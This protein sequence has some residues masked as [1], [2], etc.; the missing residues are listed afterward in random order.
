MDYLGLIAFIVGFGW[1]PIAIIIAPIIVLI[2]GS[3]KMREVRWKLTRE[4]YKKYTGENGSEL[5]SSEKVPTYIHS[6]YGYY[7]AR[8]VEE[9]DGYYAYVNI[10]SG[11]D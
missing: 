3:K 4:E 7:G 9:D 5:F 2:K 8:F 1:M 11:C 10:G 6:G